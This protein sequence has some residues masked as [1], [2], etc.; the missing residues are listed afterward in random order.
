MLQNVLYLWHHSLFITNILQHFLWRRSRS[1]IVWYLIYTGMD[2]TNQ[3]YFQNAILL[4]TL[5]KNTKGA[6]QNGMCFAVN[7]YFIVQFL[8]HFSHICEKLN[9]FRC[10]MWHWNLVEFH[11]LFPL[12][13]RTIVRIFSQYNKF[14]IYIYLIFTGPWA[15]NLTQTVFPKRFNFILKWNRFL[16]WLWI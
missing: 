6:E 9:V 3:S 13:W 4:I 14:D 8:I 2:S 15:C 12:F 16:F 5:I 11:N 7:K 1:S 10:F